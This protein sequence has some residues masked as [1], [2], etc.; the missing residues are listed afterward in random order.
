[1]NITL[2]DYIGSISDTRGM[3]DRDENRDDIHTLMRGMDSLQIFCTSVENIKKNPEIRGLLKEYLEDETKGEFTPK[4]RTFVCVLEKGDEIVYTSGANSR[5]DGIL[6]LADEIK[7]YYGC[8]NLRDSN[9]LFQDTA[10][11][12]E[13]HDKSGKILSVK[14]DFETILVEERKRFFTAIENSLYDMFSMYKSGLEKRIEELQTERSK[15][16]RE[17]AFN[18]FKQAYDFAQGHKHLIVDKKDELSDKIKDIIFRTSHPSPIWSAINNRGVTLIYSYIRTCGKS[19]FEDECKSFYNDM[20]GALKVIFKEQDSDYSDYL[21]STL[22]MMDSIYNKYLEKCGTFYYNTAK[23][24]LYPDDE[25]WRYLYHL[26][27]NTIP[28]GES[29]KNK[30]AN[31]LQGYICKNGLKDELVSR[32]FSNDF[33]DALLDYLSSEK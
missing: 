11:I 33:F 19:I 20:K 8:D 15:Q 10:P 2:P 28:G 12:L 5:E 24:S 3:R 6:I 25:L 29:Y 7:S 30:V 16:V 32:S 13:A 31:Y 22:G 27:G 21:N 1:M 18:M 23:K 26:W 17:S 9:I 4:Y 14:D